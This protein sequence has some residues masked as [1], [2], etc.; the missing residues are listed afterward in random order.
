MTSQL[1]VQTNW[2]SIWYAQALS[3]K[4]GTKSRP[5]LSAT[6]I[7]PYIFHVLLAAC[8]CLLPKRVAASLCAIKGN[9]K[10]AAV[11]SWVTWTLSLDPDPDPD[12][13]P[14]PNPHCNRHFNECDRIDNIQCH[15]KECPHQNIRNK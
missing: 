7:V 13:D 14:R 11:N 8:C 15:N 4:V 9:I 12:S 2:D 6:V 10:L 5:G 3:T 1:L